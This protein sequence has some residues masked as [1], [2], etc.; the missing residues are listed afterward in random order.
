[1]GE[2]E[3]ERKERSRLGFRSRATVR[4]EA[5]VAY[6]ERKLG[7]TR[8]ILRIKHGRTL[9]ENSQEG[10]TPRKCTQQERSNSEVVC[11]G[12]HLHK[13]FPDECFVPCI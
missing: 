7:E 12:Q 5:E 13:P 6:S 2:G 11:T 8:G 4:A 1:M 10:S 3:L 9:A